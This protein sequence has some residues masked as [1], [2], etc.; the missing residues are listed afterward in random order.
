LDP[1]GNVEEICVFQKEGTLEERGEKSEDIMEGWS[2]KQITI[3]S[4]GG[5]VDH[6]SSFE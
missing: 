6:R 4:C 2:P 1:G 5:D 3:V